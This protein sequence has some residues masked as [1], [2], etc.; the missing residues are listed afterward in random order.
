MFSS[1][2]QP[3]RDHRQRFRTNRLNREKFIKLKNW[4]QWFLEPSDFLTVQMVLLT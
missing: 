3:P 2:F 4:L 1:N